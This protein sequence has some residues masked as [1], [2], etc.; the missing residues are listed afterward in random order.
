[1]RYIILRFLS[2]FWG[3]FH[4]Q[5]TY[6]SR[7]RDSIKF[8]LSLLLATA[9]KS[10]TGK[11]FG[12]SGSL[13]SEKNFN[14]SKQNSQWILVESDERIRERN[15]REGE[16]KRES[17]REGEKFLRERRGKRLEINLQGG[18]RDRLFPI[19]FSLFLSQS[20]SSDVFPPV[21]TEWY[22][23]QNFFL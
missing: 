20:T 8:S 16:R 9:F 18:A 1:M 10:L 19:F 11:H 4:H 6:T 7:E 21:L 5:T 14:C 22:F 2:W 15:S 23:H 12:F 13:T 3:L 17:K